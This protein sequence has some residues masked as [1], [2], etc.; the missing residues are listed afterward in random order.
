MNKW[1]ISVPLWQRWGNY[2]LEYIRVLREF[3]I[4]LYWMFVRLYWRIRSQFRLPS[5]RKTLLYWKKASE[6]HQY[7]QKTGVPDIQRERE[8]NF[9]AL[10]RGIWTG[11]SLLASVTSTR[12]YESSSLQRCTTKRKGNGH[13]L[14]YR[15]FW[16]DCRKIFFDNEGSHWKVIQRWCRLYIL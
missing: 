3:N 9:S 2:I 6:S 12:W 16:F 5:T 7:E 11:T 15:K 10:R 1:N 8:R 4:L 14:Q 13:K